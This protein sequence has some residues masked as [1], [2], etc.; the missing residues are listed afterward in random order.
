M[1]LQAAKFQ[2]T[3]APY[4]L[5]C[6]WLWWNTQYL[7]G[8]DKHL[9]ALLPGQVAQLV[10]SQLLVCPDNDH[11]DQKPEKLKNQ[12]SNLGFLSMN[13]CANWK[14]CKYCRLREKEIAF[15]GGGGCTLMVVGTGDL[16]FAC[17][18]QVFAGLCK[19]SESCC[20]TGLVCCLG[21]WAGVTDEW[22]LCCVF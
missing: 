20:R 2:V 11:S 21:P 7:K 15:R 1:L 5:V 12:K 3:M 18:L 6:P 19:V 4:L 9:K 13:E 14:E 22:L 17:Y 10:G 16:G 8:A